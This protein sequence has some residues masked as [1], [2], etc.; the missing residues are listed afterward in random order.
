MFPTLEEFLVSVKQHELT[1]NLDHELYRDLTIKNPETNNRM[2]HVTTRPYYITIYGDMGTFTFSRTKDMFAFFRNDD[3]SIKPS[4]YH[5][6]MQ[7][8][9]KLTKSLEFSCD[10]IIEQL[11]DYLENFKER[12]L[13]EGEDESCYESAEQAV[14]R[15]IKYTERSENEYV[16]EINNWNPES[17][18]NMDLD[19]F[20]DGFSGMI[21]S[22]HYIWCL[23]AITYAIKLYDESKSTEEK[24]DL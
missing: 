6:K 5:E 24:K 8:E 22:Y 9:D 4:Y 11:N 2:Y 23:Y 10:Q 16:Y 20:W 12:C 17:S 18:G 7:S 14:E 13:D 19:D 21:Y 1:I 3:L 15:F